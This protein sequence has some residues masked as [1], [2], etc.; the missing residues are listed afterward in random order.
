MMGCE[1][2]GERRSR[3]AM[4]LSWGG[5]IGR[6]DGLGEIGERLRRDEGEGREGGGGDGIEVA[7]S[8]VEVVV[9]GGVES[10]VAA[11]PATRFPTLLIPS[12]PAAAPPETNLPA[13]STNVPS[14]PAP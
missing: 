11:N 8:F 10:E 3:I 4:E 12:S 9:V 1:R 2:L 6:R 5:R 14:T 13:T 7:G